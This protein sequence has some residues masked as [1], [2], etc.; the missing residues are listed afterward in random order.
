RVFGQ[1][2]LRIVELNEPP[3][4]TDELSALSE[5][6]E[7]LKSTK[8]ET[9]TNFDKL[10]TSLIGET[11]TSI[12]TQLIK[13]RNQT[14]DNQKEQEKQSALLEK[15]QTSLIGSEEV[16]LLTQLEKLRSQLSDN[17]IEQKEHKEALKSINETLGAENDKSI[18]SQIKG[19]KSDQNKNNKALES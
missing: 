5:I 12:S 10:N 2:I 13:L 16:S 15:I 3:K 17:Y 11:E 4:Q 6:L 18:L 1:L 19:L 7:V 14:T 8:T 9:K